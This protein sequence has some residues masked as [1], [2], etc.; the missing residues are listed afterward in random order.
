MTTALSY[1]VD[2]PNNYEWH[3]YTNDYGN[4]MTVVK[5]WVT[6][7]SVETNEFQDPPTLDQ[8][9]KLLSELRDRAASATPEQ[10]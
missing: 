10:P 4:R 3:Q 2:I 8:V 9:A 7:W 5:C 1:T 6:G